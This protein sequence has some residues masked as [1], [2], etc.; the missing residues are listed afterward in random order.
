MMYK[1]VSE[2]LVDICAYMCV[3]APYQGQEM[4]T[5][6]QNV[7]V[8]LLGEEHIATGEVKYTLGPLR[9]LYMIDR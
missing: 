2:C 4:L 8:H 1:H 9:L 3:H 7:R 5:G 6:V